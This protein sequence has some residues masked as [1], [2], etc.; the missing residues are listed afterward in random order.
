MDNAGRGGVQCL[1]HKGRTLLSVTKA[2]DQLVAGMR[3]ADWLTVE[4][5]RAWCRILAVITALMVM[6]WIVTSHGGLDLWGKPIGADFVSFW[7]A[8]HF[9]IDGHAALAYDPIAHVALQRAL[10]PADKPGYYAFFYPPVFLLICLPI[11]LLPFFS[12]LIVWL[13][14]SFAALFVCLRRIL[15][16]RWAVLPIVVFPGVLINAGHGQN[17][18]LSAACLGWSMLLL[19]RRPFI[20]GLCLGALIYKPQLLL[21]VP[22]ALLAARRWKV[23]GG[24]VTSSMGLI[25]ISWI[26]LGEDSWRGF[27]HASQ[28]ARETLE[29]G[30]V[31]PWKMQSAFAAVRLLHG[32]VMLAYAVQVPVTLAACVLLGWIAA[33]RPGA[34]AEGALMVV[35]TLFSTPFLLSYDLVYLALPIAWITAEAQLTAWHPW[36]KTVLL[37][38]YMLPL[39]SLV[40][41]QAGIP[42]APVVLASLLVVVARRAAGFGAAG[43]AVSRG[44]LLRKS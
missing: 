12:S 7:T 44:D 2:L 38:A 32:S 29:Q 43:C 28:F 9:A 10:F 39:I 19:Q 40:V 26:V 36:E 23:I 30:L 42:I 6:G 13:S 4:R 14:A 25:V 27:L 20:S 21:G 1:P 17:G 3:D 5:S 16:Q 18:F 35:A 8:S 34:S 31:E 37:A 15:P 11:A 22:V 24:A 41:G 33:R